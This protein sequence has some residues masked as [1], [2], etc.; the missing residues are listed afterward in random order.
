MQRQLFSP[1]QLSTSLCVQICIWHYCFTEIGSGGT[2]RLTVYKDLFRWPTKSWQGAPFNDI[3]KV[4]IQKNIYRICIYLIPL[5]R[6]S[7]WTNC[8]AHQLTLNQTVLYQIPWSHWKIPWPF[9]KMNNYNHFSGKEGITKHDGQKSSTVKNLNFWR[10]WLKPQ[11]ENLVERMWKFSAVFYAR[12]YRSS[13]TGQLCE[14]EALTALSTKPGL[15]DDKSL[16]HGSSQHFLV[17]E[18]AEYGHGQADY[19]FLQEPK[20]WLY[21]QKSA[22]L[23]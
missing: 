18:P 20:R 13:L 9:F 22:C 11:G 17:A 4:L 12:S 21:P 19:R 2:Y 7:S 10:L 1:I 16:L 14:W 6:M 3:P 15:V 8:C 23:C 5:T